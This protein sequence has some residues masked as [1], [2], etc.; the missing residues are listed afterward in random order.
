MDG[1]IWTFVALEEKKK[2]IDIPRLRHL[3]KNSVR[4]GRA[5]R[6]R[7]RKKPKN[8]IINNI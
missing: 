8:K 6:E 1:L 5:M 3:G 7:G 2:N 4:M